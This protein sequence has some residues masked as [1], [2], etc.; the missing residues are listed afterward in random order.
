[1]VLPSEKSSE[2]SPSFVLRPR[3]DEPMPNQPAR[4]GQRSSMHPLKGSLAEP[5][6]T[7]DESSEARGRLEQQWRIFDTT[8]SSINDFAYMFDRQG[9]FLYVNRPLLDLWGLTLEEAA[10]KNFFD[11]QYP[12]ELASRLQRQIQEVF[13]TKE[14]VTD[15]T[16]YTSPTG[17]VGYYEYIFCPVIGDDGVVELVVG[18]TRDV[19]ER[20][21]AEAILVK[22]EKLSA[23]GRLAAALAHEINNPLQAVM[24]LMMLLRRSPRLDGQDQAYA[25]MAE[26]ELGR[27]V[28]LTQQALGFYR[29]AI[30]PREVNA[31]EVVE[32]VLDSYAKRMEGARITVNRRYSSAAA[33]LTS[34]PGEIRQVFSIL[35][36][37]AIEAQREGGTISVRVRRVQQGPDLERCGVRITIADSGIGIPKN[38]AARVFEPFFTTKEQQGTGLGLWVASGIVNRLRG[39]IRMRSSVSPGKSGTCFSIFLP[40][41]IPTPR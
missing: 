24:N 23:A 2:R 40:S 12:E 38:N 41:Y 36:V 32:S 14:K 9:R 39:S 20:K 25:T 19:T 1:L 16:S 15:E 26:E 34:Y 5:K 17:V 27:I 13:A 29:E 11:L 31:E 8:L 28:H 30:F 7:E 3:Q 22:S 4:A 37:N 35:L 6:R 10:G 33:T 18:S 21:K